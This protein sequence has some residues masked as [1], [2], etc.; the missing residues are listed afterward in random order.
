MTQNIQKRLPVFPNM[1]VFMLRYCAVVKV[2]FNIKQLFV[3]DT[4]NVMYRNNNYVY[5]NAR[6][7]GELSS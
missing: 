6:N 5:T 2:S 1:Y 7:I 4:L 3:N